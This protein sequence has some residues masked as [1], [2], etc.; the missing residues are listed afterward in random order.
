MVKA[1]LSYGSSYA[2]STNLVCSHLGGFQ[3]KTFSPELSMSGVDSVARPTFRRVA[4]RQRRLLFHVS[5]PG[6][7][8]VAAVTGPQLRVPVPQRRL[9]LRPGQLRI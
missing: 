5:G 1:C 8:P 4:H 7:L 3:L 6:R 2:K 9:L